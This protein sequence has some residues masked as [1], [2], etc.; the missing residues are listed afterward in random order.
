MTLEA[1]LAEPTVLPLPR[2]NPR[3]AL[4]HVFH[5][6]W[7]SAGRALSEE[8]ASGPRAAAHKNLQML[9]PDTREALLLHTVEGFSFQEVAGILGTT[10]VAARGL[11]DQARSDMADAIAG[12]VLIIE[13]E[14]IIAADLEAIALNDEAD[15]PAMTGW[16]R[17]VFG[18]LALKLKH[19]KLA[20]G[21][22]GKSVRLIEDE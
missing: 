20:L 10:A 11:V 4:Y 19:G 5:G 1:I 6:V 2:L 16:R 8:V 17:K 3:T 15:V 7:V 14:G 21:L 9:A 13:D 12:R 22:K 18:G